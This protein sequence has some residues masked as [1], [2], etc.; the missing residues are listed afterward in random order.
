[1][2]DERRSKQELFG[3]RD[4]SLD[5]VESR[6]DRVVVAFSWADSEGRYHTLVQALRLKHGKIIDIQDWANLTSA[7]AYMRLRTALG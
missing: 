3:V 2:L 4:Y 5:S 6:C 7:L 1:V